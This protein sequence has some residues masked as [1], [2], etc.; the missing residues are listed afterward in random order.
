[1]NRVEYIAKRLEVLASYI[2]LNLTTTIQRDSGLVRY[3]VDY[4]A[5]T[6][7]GTLHVNALNGFTSDVVN[8]LSH[9]SPLKNLATALHHQLTSFDAEA[10]E[11]LQ[12]EED[13]RA[14]RK[15]NTINPFDLPGKTC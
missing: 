11:E 2:K 12:Y 6:A 9:D 7:R 13:L 14:A 1:V 4:R 15:E 3:T 10:E 5:Q 8:D